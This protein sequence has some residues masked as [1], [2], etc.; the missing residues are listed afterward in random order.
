MDI[1]ISEIKDYLMRFDMVDLQS[2]QKEFSLTYSQVRR[3]F[4]ELLKQDAVSFISGFTYKVNKACII[5]WDG[6]SSSG[7]K[8]DALDE[9]DE[10]L[11]RALREC[12]KS[13]NV[14]ASG[15]Q[16]KLSIRY[17]FAA[18]LVER[19]SKLELINYNERK[20]LIT[21]NE[22]NAR[23]GNRF[24]IDIDQKI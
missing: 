14:S 7:K 22:F 2:V 15:L 9:S 17:A 23:F 6:L 8:L 5:A 20:V 21:A 13:N 19:L 24:K 4:Y 3:F 11:I 18:R 16:R 10:M 12:I 1:D